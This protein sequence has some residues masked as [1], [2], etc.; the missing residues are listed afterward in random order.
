MA[1]I[2]VVLIKTAQTRVLILDMLSRY[3]NNSKIKGS[4][5]GAQNNDFF[6]CVRNKNNPSSVGTDCPPN[7]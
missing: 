1:L 4:K 5:K 7:H 2:K 6:C 3:E